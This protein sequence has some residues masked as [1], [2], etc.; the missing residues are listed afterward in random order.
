MIYQRIN[1]CLIFCQGK[2]PH[3][4]I[5]E[6]YFLFPQILNAIDVELAEGNCLDCKKYIDRRALST[7]SALGGETLHQ[8]RTTMASEIEKRQHGR[9]AV[10]YLTRM[11]TSRSV[12]WKAK[13]RI[14]YGFGRWGFFWIPSAWWPT[15]YFVP[16]WE[17]AECELRD[18]I[19]SLLSP[20]W[21]TQFTA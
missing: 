15:I 16:H 10:R 20:F 9:I 14:W 17:Q 11:V 12:M 7:K 19:S 4:T 1:S 8:R 18:V 21:A 6:R 2:C 5:M 3:F 13:Q